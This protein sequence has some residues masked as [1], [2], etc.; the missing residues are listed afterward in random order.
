MT[1]AR[2]S[3]NSI[4]KCYA[5]LSMETLNQA[6]ILPIQNY[7][8]LQLKGEGVL[9]GF[10]DSGIDYENEV[11]RNID[12]TTRI[13]AI[14]DQT[15]QS[16]TPPDGFAYGSEYSREMIDAAL[17]SEDPLSLVPSADESGHGYLR[18]KHCCRRSQ[19]RRTVS[20]RRPGSLH[21]HGQAEA[22]KGVPER[23]LLYPAQRCLLPGD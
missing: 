7:P 13:E 20:R 14:W 2:F 19:C 3:Y 12:G 10:L 22:G 23:L 9:I 1:L 5:P 8:T 4:P 6:G 16:G 15:V 17:T 18:R 11:F 21:R